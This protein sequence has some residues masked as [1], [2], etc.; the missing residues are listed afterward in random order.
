MA[1]GDGAE[2]FATGVLGIRADDNILLAN[3]NS[4]M[5]LSDVIWDIAPGLELDFGK[6]AQL[7]GSLTLVDTFIRYGSHTRYNTNLFAGNF[8]T[9]YDDAKFKLGFNAGYN[10]LN[11]N[12]VDLRGLVRRDI[13]NVGVNSEVNVS[14]LTA[15]G[16]AFNF[17]HE[18]YHP[19]NYIDSDTLSVPLN[20]YYR[21]TPKLDVS[22]GY[23]YREYE[24]KNGSAVD[25]TD[26][27]Y[28]VGLR[29]EFSPK[30]TGKVA[31]GY[32]QRRFESVLK[33]RSLF[34]LD[35][36]L[37]YE[38]TP[39]TA[40]QFGAANDFGTSPTG[41]QQK[42]FTVNSLV[43][44]KLTEEISLNAGASYRGIKYDATP[45]N[46]AR[47]DDYWET[48]LGASYAVNVHLRLVGAW[49]Y[50]TYQTDLAGSEFDNNVF[51]FAANIRY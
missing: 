10:E 27:F 21:W 16:G 48:V 11:Q 4:G 12:T 1:V 42:N 14:D 29:G 18:N 37:A 23:T 44:T 46:R 3:D 35:A 41:Q 43:T 9:K 51:S 49:T 5:K 20:F 47:T 36:S 8:V 24:A 13:A 25:S 33:S 15:V 26:H 39:K 50:R 38:I 40:V 6:N 30:L 7:Q 22:L 32:T 2:I 17:T 34:G 31:V 19:S 28:N 45:L